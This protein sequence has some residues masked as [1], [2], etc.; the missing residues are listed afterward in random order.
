MAKKKNKPHLSIQKEGPREVASTDCKSG[1]E[2]KTY[3][4]N[5]IDYEGDMSDYVNITRHSTLAGAIREAKRFAMDQKWAGPGTNL[6]YA[7]MPPRI[8]RTVK[9]VEMHR[10]EVKG[11][12]PKRAALPRMELLMDGNGKID[13]KRMNEKQTEDYKKIWDQFEESEAPNAGK[14]H[15]GI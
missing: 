12:E 15:P 3:Y 5:I 6:F 11:P 1:V 8:I 9:F 2:D 10:V 7:G 14:P 4:Y 13:H